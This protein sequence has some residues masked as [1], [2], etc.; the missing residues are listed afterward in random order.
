M[1]KVRCIALTVLAD[2][3]QRTQQ[4]LS[5][6]PRPIPHFKISLTEPPKLQLTSR[7]GHT[8]DP[9]NLGDGGNEQKKRKNPIKFFLPTLQLCLQYHLPF[10]QPPFGKT[11][12]HAEKDEKVS[13]EDIHKRLQNKTNKKYSQA[14]TRIHFHGLNTRLSDSQCID[15]IPFFLFSTDEATN[16][17]RDKQN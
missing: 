17:I 13:R 5:I 3:F 8:T 2:A 6:R 16:N 15:I 9:P 10:L 12:T 14:T 1:C 7:I 4:Y 11:K